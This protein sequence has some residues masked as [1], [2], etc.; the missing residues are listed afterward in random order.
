MARLDGW[1][2]ERVREVLL[3]GEAVVDIGQ[4]SD[5]ARKQLRKWLRDGQVL[6]WVYIG[7]PMAKTAWIYPETF[8]GEAHV[9]P[10][11]PREAEAA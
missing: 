2:R 1:T 4:L 10:A 7:F 8:K 11:D 6:K 3:N 9:F 5:A